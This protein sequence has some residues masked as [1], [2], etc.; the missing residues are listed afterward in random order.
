MK[1]TINKVIR[2]M[3]YSDFVF[4]SGWGFLGPVF[5]IFI[6]QKIADGDPIEGAKIAGFASLSYWI[7]K[8]ILQIPIGK[9][10][11]KNHGEKDDF[12]F[13]VF[14]TFLTGLVPFGFIFSSQPW[15]IYAFHALHAVGMAMVVPS[16]SAIFTRHI[17]KGREAFEWSLRSTS[18][19]FAAGIAGAL[20]GIL[21]AAYG[22]N[23][24]FILAG[25]LSMVSS[26]MLLGIDKEIAVRDHISPKFPYPF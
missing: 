7:I 9:N 6:V 13:M 18:L 25:S 22:F 26:L 5:A 2:F 10:L 3:I 17:D 14:G 12:R 8:S 16:W 20:G 1:K 11:D 15:H 19:G 4:N 24:I 21:V 23:V